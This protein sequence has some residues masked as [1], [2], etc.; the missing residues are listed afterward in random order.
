MKEKKLIE[1]ILKNNK[2][3]INRFYK[4]YSS[5]L[6]NYILTRIDNPKDG[7]E[8]LQDTFVAGLDS[9]PTFKFR[10]SLYTWLCSISR[11]EIADFYRR[12]KIKTLI[13]SQ[14][15]FLEKIVDRALGPQLAMEEK[16]LKDKIGRTLHSLSE[17][18]CRI[19]RLKYIEGQSL[20][21]IA[22]KMGKSV[23]AAESK[24]TRARIAFRKEYV[25][26]NQR[27]KIKDQSSWAKS[28]PI[29]SSFD[30]QGGVSF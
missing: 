18:Y 26:Q 16:E 9:L 20:A 25:R 2:K 17:G 21:Q 11:H 23:K 5:R 8:I 7:E 22:Q 24:L 1:Q 6:L 30:N 19:L 14:F 29:F 15:P 27:S 3:A 13:F 4:I 28:F 10:S 12:K